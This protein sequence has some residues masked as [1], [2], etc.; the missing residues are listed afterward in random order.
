MKESKVLKT[1]GILMIIGGVVMMLLSV[2][3]LLGGAVVAGADVFLGG[4]FLL[5]SVI[6]ILG[7]V[8]EFIAGI[9][10]LKSWN[11][12]EKAHRCVVMGVVLILFSVVSGAG[13]I[14]ISGFTVNTAVS[15][16]LGLIL[17]ILYIYGASSIKDV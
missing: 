16:F 17:P 2:L 14:V 11:H 13:S 7:A 3:S 15:L 4:L 12:P 1:A 9:W 8:L 6:G 10:G 5:I